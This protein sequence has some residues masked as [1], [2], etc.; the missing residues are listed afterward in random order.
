MSA[1]IRQNPWEN[2]LPQLLMQMTMQKMQQNW[3]EKQNVQATESKAA[4]TRTAESVAKKK[5]AG[6]RIAAGHKPH[7]PGMP[8]DT[9][10]FESYKGPHGQTFLK[11]K[12]T[13]IKGH[14]WS[15]V[16]QKHI[17]LPEPQK[18]SYQLKTETKYDPETR[19][20]YSRSYNYSPSTGEKTKQGTWAATKETVGKTEYDVAS[21]KEFTQLRNQQQGT[22]DSLTLLN[23]LEKLAIEDPTIIGIV[24]KGQKLIN[25][26][27]EQMVA[28][29][30]VFTGRKAIVKGKPAKE[31][32]LLNPSNYGMTGFGEAAG[33]SAAF[34]STVIRLAY[35]MARAQDPGG[36]LSDRD[37]QTAIDQIGGNQGSLTQLKSTLAQTRK[38]IISSYKIKHRIV[39]GKEASKDLFQN[40]LQNTSG[41]QEGV[42]G[43]SIKTAENY[44]ESIGY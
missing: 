10:R 18:P 21:K 11:S 39:T 25:R 44:L 40:Y 37:V 19:L 8:F 9:K 2:I 26:A 1:I 20:T 7:T 22:E 4:K 27:A 15:S 14:K 38:N 34:K 32:E 12:P 5:F 42:S 36:R 3:Q 29:S 24:G 41:R 33:K 28:A 16:Q 43:E 23:E 35:T 17:K 30:K 13:Q 31:S 6:G